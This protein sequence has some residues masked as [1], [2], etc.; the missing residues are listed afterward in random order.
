MGE[1][2]VVRTT[3]GRESQ[4]IEK[5][6]ARVK[7][8]GLPV[9]AILKPREVK[10]YFFVEAEELDDVN[11]AVYGIQHA[12]GVLGTVKLDEI[13]KFLIPTTESIKIHAGDIVEIVSGPFKGEKAKVKRITKV[14]E[15]VV[16]E[17]LEAAVPI[18]ITVKLDSVRLIKTEEKKE[19]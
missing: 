3:T 4:V 16:V 5:V 12:K 19:E 6:A 2:F 18:P 1:I 14:K 11:R 7:Q 17:L 13:K 8:Q 9:F 10:G 15:E